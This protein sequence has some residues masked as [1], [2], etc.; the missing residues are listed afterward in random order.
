MYS[1]LIT[2][3]QAVREHPNADKLSLATVAGNQVV[4]GLNSKEGDWVVYFDVDGQLSRDFASAANLFRK[5]EFN[6]DKTKTGMFDLNA[7]IRAQAFRGSKSEGFAMPIEDVEKATKSKLPREK[8]NEITHVG[9]M[10]LCNKYINPNTL[11]AQGTQ[12]SSKKITNEMFHKHFDTAQFGRNDFLIGNDDIVIITEKLH[13]TSQR[14]ANVKIPQKRNFLQKIFG[15]TPKPV[16][17]DMIGTRN[18]ILD[19]KKL[20]DDAGFHSTSFR[21]RASEQFLGNIK[22]GETFYYE[23]VGY[24]NEGKPIMGSHGNDKLKGHLDK[25]SYKD[26]IN[27]YG[28]STVFSYGCPEG[29]LAV[30]VYRITLTNEDGYSIDLS[31]DAVVERCGEL[32]ISTVPELYRGTRRQ[33]ARL[34]ALRRSDIDGRETDDERDI[35]EHSMEYIKFLSVGKTKLGHNLSEGVCLRVEK[36][37]TPLVLKEK[38][39][40]FKVLEGIIKSQED[41]VDTEEAEG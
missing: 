32:G 24:E 12:K 27:S 10:E 5:G 14:V 28:D 36:G 16:W 19:D 26:F 37:L 9:K 40:Q 20:K 30:Y 23:V 34:E 39:F 6:K 11:K 8:G 2:Q 15:V 13:G 22:K 38:S 17:R 25:E 41:Y 31:W 21:Q 1:A 7:R 33:M 29:E 3:L 35:Q 18:V 4:V